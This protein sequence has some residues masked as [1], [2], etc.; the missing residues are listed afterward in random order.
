MIAFVSAAPHWG[1]VA[2]LGLLIVAFVWLAYAGVRAIS[3]WINHMIDHNSIED[4]ADAVRYT[5]A[6]IDAIAQE[7]W[8]R[9]YADGCEQDRAYGAHAGV[10]IPDATA[11]ET[12]TVMPAVVTGQLVSDVDGVS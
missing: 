5:G 2:L 9:G 7:A 3:L 4:V 1:D 11:V 12:T 6:D 10:D 8:E